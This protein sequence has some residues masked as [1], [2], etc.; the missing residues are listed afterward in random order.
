MTVVKREVPMIMPSITFCDY[1]G[2]NINNMILGCYFGI[3]GGTCLKDNLTVYDGLYKTTC[4]RFNFGSNATILQNM[5]REGYNFGYEIRL[6]LPNYASV[7]LGFTDNND[8]AVRS[9]INK[10]II[11]GDHNEISLSKSNQQNLPDP[12]S[13]CEEKFHLSVKGSDV[14]YRQV[15]CAELCYNRVMSLICKCEWPEDCPSSKLSNDCRN[16]NTV[17][18]K[19][20]IK[21]DCF[22][23]CPL[24]CNQVAFPVTRLNIKLEDYWVDIYKEDISKKFD[25][26]NQTNEQIASRMAIVWI[27]YDSLDTTIITQ[28][29]KTT[30]L[31]LISNIGG[32]LGIFKYL[33]NLFNS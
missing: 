21:A 6:Y 3:D 8:L 27:Y 23:E 2:G 4:V 18:N 30:M 9:D 33:F 7:W 22:K 17:K 29:P 15:N 20:L 1:G 24:E 13:N 31:D 10:Y 19:T 12:F 16:A 5:E 14:N 32:I 26:R 11:P 28:T 25:I